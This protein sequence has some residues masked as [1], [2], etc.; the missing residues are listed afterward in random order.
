LENAEGGAYTAAI[1]ENC[2]HTPHIEQPETYL[3]HVNEFLQKN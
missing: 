3:Q 1:I 2:G